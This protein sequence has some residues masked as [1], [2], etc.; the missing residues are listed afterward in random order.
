M[1]RQ[2]RP[3]RRGFTLVEAI[4]TMAILAVVSLSASRIIFAASDAYATDATRSQLTLDLSA[5]MERIASE[6]RAVPSRES[7]PGTPWIDAVSVNAIT[8]GDGSEL[9][10]LEETLT[11]LSGDGPA[12]ILLKNVASFSLACFDE[13]GQAIALPVT[14]AGCNSIRRIQVTV[15]C[16]RHGVTETLRTRV[17]LRCAAGQSG[18]DE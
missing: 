7:A 10:Y 15:S 14:G 2:L 9:E 11:L 8:Y 4:A 12:C 16:T 17:F 13:A 1:N 3:S 5:A 6:L 18:G